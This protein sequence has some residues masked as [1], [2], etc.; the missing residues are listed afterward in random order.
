MFEVL[1]AHCVDATYV[2]NIIL[3]QYVSIWKTYFEDLVNKSGEYMQI[4]MYQTYKEASSLN[5]EQELEEISRIERK[6]LD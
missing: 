3:M 4:L 1:S 5:K 2:I 6:T